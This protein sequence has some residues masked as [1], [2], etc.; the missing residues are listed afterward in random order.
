MTKQAKVNLSIFDILGRKIITLAD[1]YE[2]SGSYE[3]T[4]DAYNNASGVY[5]YRLQQIILFSIKR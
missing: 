5:I 1:D 4:F 2:E 3:Y